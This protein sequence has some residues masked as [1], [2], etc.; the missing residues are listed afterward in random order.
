MHCDVTVQK[1]QS[2]VYVPVAV[3]GA[4]ALL[5]QASRGGI[6]GMEGAAEAASGGGPPGQREPNDAVLVFGSTGK[7]GRLVVQKVIYGCMR[8][9]SMP[10]C[11][12][13]EACERGEC[14]HGCRGLSLYQAVMVAP[15][16]Y[17]QYLCLVAEFCNCAVSMRIRAAP[18]MHV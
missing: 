8:L 11:V 17:L 14:M 10:S 1:V 2:A 4:G 6:S 15:G 18:Q 5:L 16:S 7:L 12:K 3:L 9:C 13:Q